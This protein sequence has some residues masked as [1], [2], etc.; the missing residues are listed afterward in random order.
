MCLIPPEVK[1]KPNG[2]PP[3]LLTAAS[4]AS[5][6]PL[7][8][9]PPLAG[10][11]RAVPTSRCCSRGGWAWRLF[12]ASWASASVGRAGTR[13]WRRA[14]VKSSATPSP[15]QGLPIQ[16]V[17]GGKPTVTAAAVGARPGLA[18]AVAVGGV[19]GWEVGCAAPIALVAAL[20]FRGA[21]VAAPRLLIQVGGHG[22]WWR[23]RVPP[24]PHGQ[25][26]WHA[27]RGGGGVAA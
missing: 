19:G 2:P 23:R 12:P 4:D 13:A 10:E 8:P 14:G 25:T 17:W 1:E 27:G 21:A 9:T 24:P 5:L 3:M 26:T 11:E 16:R 15:T 22:F 20:A 7:P 6:A 18:V